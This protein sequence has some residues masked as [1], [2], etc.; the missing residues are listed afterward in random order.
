MGRPY[1]AGSQWIFLE[2]LRKNRFFKND[3]E[4]HFY[5]MSHLANLDQVEDG[6]ALA[7]VDWDH[8]GRL[9]LWYRN[10]NAPR[11]RFMHNQS[12]AGPSLSVKLR[13]TRS[14][15]DGIGATVELLP[16]EK[17]FRLVRSLRAGD[18]FLSQSSKWL[19]FGTASNT[20]KKTARVTWPSGATEEFHNLPAQGRVLLTEGSGKAELVPKRSPVTLVKNPA[21][22]AVRDSG[23]AQVVL[24]ARIPFPQLEFQNAS[25]EKKSLTKNTS[26]KLLLLWSEQCPHCQSIFPSLSKHATELHTAGLEVIA[27]SAASLSSSTAATQ[28][29]KTVDSS[30]QWGFI[31][32]SSMRS[33]FQFQEQLFDRTPSATVP[34]VILL[35]EMNQALALYRGPFSLSS[36]LSDWH[37]LKAAS[38]T[39]RF[40]L[41]P[42]L[43]GTWFTN[44]LPPR[45]VSRILPAPK[46]VPDEK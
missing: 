12:E 8:D 13:G 19:H 34:L 42:P 36:I 15:R 45:E 37:I 1:E 11:L 9:D 31:E 38:P 2:W 18:L 40:H 20:I 29:M 35:D 44:P 46:V 33:L 22:N 10:R 27:L 43:R 17:N 5:E 26:P 21:P 30:H 25:G 3:G 14:N 28:F 32:S 16:S 6:R 24:P 4:G 41:A 39:Q 7:L 23:T